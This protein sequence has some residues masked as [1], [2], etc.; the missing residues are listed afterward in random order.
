MLG[1]KPGKSLPIIAQELFYSQLEKEYLHSKF[2]ITVVD[3]PDVFS[4]IDKHTLVVAPCVP[5]TCDISQHELPAAMIVNH[6]GCKDPHLVSERLP[7]A[8]EM[9]RHYNESEISPL[10]MRRTAQNQLEPL[11][12]KAFMPNTNLWVKKGDTDELGPLNYVPPD[13][14]Q[15]VSKEGDIITF[16]PSE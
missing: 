8:V 13:E 11:P 9:F 12:N 16:A 6:P 4:H 3:D 7:K 2:G 5:I 1:G 15:Q 14:W 10:K